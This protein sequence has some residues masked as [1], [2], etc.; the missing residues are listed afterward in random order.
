MRGVEVLLVEDNPHDL[1][2]TM[3]A[4]EKHHLANR[5]S[6]VRD[7]A[8]ALDFIFARGAWSHR[9]VDETPQVIF[10]DLKLP[11]VDGLEVLRQV[12]GDARTKHIP[13]VIITSSAEE[14]D[15]LASYDLGV[16]SFVV[17]PV[18]FPQFTDAMRQL[19]LYWTMLNQVQAE[20]SV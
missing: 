1:A 13:V 14:R 2:M 15:R 11:K 7:G 8:E 18:E 19:G 16:N 9:K 17:K 4:L 6:A 5:L 10:L 20:L 3:R 12:K